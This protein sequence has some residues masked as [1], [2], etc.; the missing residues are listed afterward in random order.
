MLLLILISD[1]GTCVNH[2]GS[3]VCICLDGWT[4]EDCNTDITECA[5]N[6]CAHNSTCVE[7]VNG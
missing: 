5:S 6:P 4:G 1:S 7:G 2:P 3:H